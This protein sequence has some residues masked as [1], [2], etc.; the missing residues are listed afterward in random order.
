MYLSALAR[1]AESGFWPRRK[2]LYRAHQQWR[3]GKETADS[4]VRKMAA[5]RKCHRHDKSLP[6]YIWCYRER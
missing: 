5:G 2:K 3:T 1:A 6:S 4:V